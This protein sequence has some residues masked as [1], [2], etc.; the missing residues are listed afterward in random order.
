[1]LMIIKLDKTY[2]ARQ[3]FKTIGSSKGIFFAA[4]I[5]NRMMAMLVLLTQVRGWSMSGWRQPYL[6]Y[7]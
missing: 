2:N 6:T 5:M 7:I 3:P 4:C 1:M